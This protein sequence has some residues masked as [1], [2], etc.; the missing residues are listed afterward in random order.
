MLSMAG[1]LLVGTGTGD[2]ETG[3]GGTETGGWRGGGTGGQPARSF[4]VIG[5]VY[6]CSILCTF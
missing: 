6:I 1:G 2:R 3:D 4:V 5:R